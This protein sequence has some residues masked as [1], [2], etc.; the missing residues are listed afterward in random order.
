MKDT[1]QHRAEGWAHRLTLKTGQLHWICHRYV[2]T[3]FL[4]GWSLWE[5]RKRW[6]CWPLYVGV[7][8]FHAYDGEQV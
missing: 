5:V 3:A 4:G 1:G 6:F 7:A 2:D 8:T